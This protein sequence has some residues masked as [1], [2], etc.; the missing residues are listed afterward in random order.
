M[1]HD[2]K[3]IYKQLKKCSVLFI[4]EFK[5][6]TVGKSLWNNTLQTMLLY[7]KKIKTKPFRVDVNVIR[8]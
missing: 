8:V 6:V 4:K 1:F 5:V 3:C 7:E 2:I